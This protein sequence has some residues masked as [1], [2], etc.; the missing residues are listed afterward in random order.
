MFF[1]EITETDDAESF[2]KKEL[3]K[4]ITNGE[5]SA[6]FVEKKKYQIQVHKRE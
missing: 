1:S 6:E 2:D 5:K 4:L 3:Q